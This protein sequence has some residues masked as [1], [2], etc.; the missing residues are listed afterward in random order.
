M[1]ITKSLVNFANRRNLDITVENF[2]DKDLVCFW[3]KDEDSEWLFSYRI[4]EDGSLSWGGNV[5]LKQEIKEELPG[6]IFSEKQLKDVINFVS[7]AM[8]K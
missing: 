2:D 1:K 8:K 3:E 7:G 5:Y 4:S 6:T